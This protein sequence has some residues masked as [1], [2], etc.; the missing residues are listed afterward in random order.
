M[1]NL[2]S[3]RSMLEFQ[4]GW[5]LGLYQEMIMDPAADDDDIF[6]S[7]LPAVCEMQKLW[8]EKYKDEIIAFMESTGGGHIENISDGQ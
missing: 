4:L 1:D 3:P 7:L 5:Y 2:E 8:R 6:D